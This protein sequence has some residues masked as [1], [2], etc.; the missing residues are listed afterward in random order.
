M[1]NEKKQSKD[2]EID[3][4]FQD[5]KNAS[6]EERPEALEKLAER[7]SIEKISV[8]S[9]FS[10]KVKNAKLITKGEF[11]S[12]LRQYDKENKIEQNSSG[13]TKPTDDELGNEWLLNYPDTKFGLGEFRRYNNG[14]YETIPIDQIK[15]EIR[16]VLVKSKIVGIRPNESLL[17][18]V[19]E[20]SRVQI[21]IP[22]EKWNANPYL[23]PLN[24]GVFN[25]KTWDLENHCKENLFTS[26]FLFDY[27][28]LKILPK[29]PKSIKSNQLN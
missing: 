28:P 21:S 6:E 2:N 20:L 10:D 19:L 27:A 16:L 14:V 24:N 17:K 15:N 3:K 26:K 23:I 4:L 1:S 5:A 13:K 12:M 7:L 11:K 22:E 18:S 25:L 29:F 8:Q 9:Q